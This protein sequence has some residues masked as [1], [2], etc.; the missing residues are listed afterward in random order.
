MITLS[1]LVYVAAGIMI[2][3][4]LLESVPRLGGVLLLVLLMVMALAYER[5]GKVYVSG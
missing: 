5:R 4:V 1:P 3:A 2:V